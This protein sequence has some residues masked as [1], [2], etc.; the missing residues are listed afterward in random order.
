MLDEEPTIIGALAD[1]VEEVID[2]DTGQ[3]QPAPRIGMQVRVDFIRGMGKRESSFIMIL[4]IDKVF[5]AD[6]LRGLPARQRLR[7]PR[8]EEHSNGGSCTGS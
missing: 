8:P 1:S 7:K 5:T 4:D 2:L 6:E 3:I